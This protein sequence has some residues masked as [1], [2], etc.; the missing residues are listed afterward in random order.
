MD[1][2]ID[3]W[4]LIKSG[5]IEAEFEGFNDEMIFEFSDGTVYI[6][7]TYKY[8]YHYAYHPIAKIYT[9]GNLQIIVPEGMD[10]F[11]EV[12]MTS[13]IKSKIISDFNGWSG[14]TLFELQNG[15]IWRQ[16]QYQYKY[17]YAYRPDV[18]IIKSGNYHIMRVN[19][20]QI[21]VIRVK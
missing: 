19:G 16:S 20:K 4:K 1:I 18:L 15:Q 5:N 7:S 17:F 11:A 14:D 12:I 9:N 13:S 21:R 2:N 10:D 6:Q 8:K 3:D